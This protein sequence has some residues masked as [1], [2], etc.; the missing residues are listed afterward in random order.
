MRRLTIVLALAIVGVCG[1]LLPNPA[2]A[3]CTGMCPGGSFPC[4]CNGSL[5]GCATSI[6]QCFDGCDVTKAAQSM[7]VPDDSQI[8]SELKA[9]IF[10]DPQQN[11]GTREE[12]FV[13]GGTC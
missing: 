3:E 2:Q 12:L 5:I 4:C 10:A 7:F 11:G 1:L 8:L 13:P 9:A 6:Q